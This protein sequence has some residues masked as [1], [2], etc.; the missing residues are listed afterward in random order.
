MRPSIVQYQ[1][2]KGLYRICSPAAWAEAQLLANKCA[3][4]VK[5]F[6]QTFHNLNPTPKT[7]NPKLYHE[8]QPILGP[9]MR[10]C[11]GDHALGDPPHPQIEGTY[12]VMDPL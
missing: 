9:R 3:R 4:T 10:T 5:Y 8:P 7:L 6:T 11:M 2:S 12:E 1:N